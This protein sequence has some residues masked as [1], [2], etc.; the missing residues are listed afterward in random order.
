MASTDSDRHSYAIPV[1]LPRRAS[2]RLRLAHILLGLTVRRLGNLAVWTH[3]HHLLPKA[4]ALWVTTRADRLL[5]VLPPP[6]GTRLQRV[7][8]PDFR[9]EWVWDPA[10]AEP[11]EAANGAVLYFHGGALLSC[12]L[13]SHRRIVARISTA[14]GLPVYNVEYRQIPT[15]HVTETVNDCVRAYR[16]LLEIGIPSDRIVLAGDSAGGGLVFSTALAIR[17]RKLPV[18]AAL[19]AIAPFANYD[20]TARLQHPNDNVDPVLSAGVLAIPVDWGMEVNGWLNPDWSPVNHDF[21]GLPPTLIQVGSTEVLLAD[22]Y[23]VAARCVEAGV[24]LRFQLWDRALHVFH[25][26]AD[27]I[28]DARQAFSEIGTFVRDILPRPRSGDSTAKLTIARM[29]SA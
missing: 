19:V 14:T 1:E 28:P 13:N 6:R 9:A 24:P 3:R 4:V 5:V 20:S 18:P 17:D 12:G 29:T 15:A 8:F 27:V 26:G 7:D 10:A 23:E 11:P 2:R 22:A 21:S 16:R 25:A